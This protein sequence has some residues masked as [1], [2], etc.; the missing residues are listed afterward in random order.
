MKLIGSILL[1]FFCLAAN[2]QSG[3]KNSSELKKMVSK[4]CRLTDNG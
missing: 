2:S 1:L 3:K 4:S